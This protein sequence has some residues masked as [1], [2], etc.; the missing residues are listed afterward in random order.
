[1]IDMAF[2]NTERFYSLRYK[3]SLNINIYMIS[4]IKTTTGVFF[5][6]MLT[7]CV[8]VLLAPHIRVERK[9]ITHLFS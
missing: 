8:I 9:I 5:G 1:M 6:N 2:Y 4:I 3:Q 7:I